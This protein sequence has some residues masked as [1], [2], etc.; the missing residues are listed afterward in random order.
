MRYEVMLQRRAS[1]TRYEW[2]D[3]YACIYIRYSVIPHF[4]PHMLTN[5]SRYRTYRDCGSEGSKM[6][7]KAIRAGWVL[8]RDLFQKKD[9]GLPRRRR[10]ESNT[11][12]TYILGERLAAYISRS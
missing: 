8:H 2:R 11:A 5:A 1:L 3:Y 12:V 4:A 10:F 7:V 9:S 6:C